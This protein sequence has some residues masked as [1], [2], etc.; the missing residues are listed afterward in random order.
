MSSKLR[1]IKE[2]ASDAVEV[3]KEIGTPE[4]R[5]SLDKVRQTTA[6]AKEIITLIQTPEM[7]QNIGNIRS[8]AEAFQSAANSIENV[9]KQFKDSGLGDNFKH[10]SDIVKDA[11]DTVKM[12]QSNKESMAEFN[13]TIRSLRQLFDEIKTAISDSKRSGM[14]R[15]LKATARDVSETI[16]VG[17]GGP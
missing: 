3:V 9:V 17:V 13:E 10:T 2:T 7:Q 14:V 8:T 16:K 15:D 5:D 4:F 11:I 12:L 6:E 1:E